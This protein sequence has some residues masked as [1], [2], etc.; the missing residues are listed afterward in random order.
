VAVIVWLPGLKLEVL[1]DALPPLRGI[2]AREFDP[3][4]KLTMPV[5]GVGP[6]VTVDVNETD[7]PI[8]EGLGAEVNVVVV[9]NAWTFWRSMAL[10]AGKFASPL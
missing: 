10:P 6:P 8:A 1:K 3:S 7:C 2:W 9:A 4:W 5:G